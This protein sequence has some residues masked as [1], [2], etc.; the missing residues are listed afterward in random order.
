MRRQ[1]DETHFVDIRKQHV[2]GSH[3]R[4]DIVETEVA[5]HVRASLGR[6]RARASEHAEI[7]LFRVRRDSSEP[8]DIGG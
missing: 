3:A 5:V 8:K 4:S 1:D 7:L 6:R 2:A